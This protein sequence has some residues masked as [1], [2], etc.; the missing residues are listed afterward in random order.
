M[1]AI[2]AFFGVMAMALMLSTGAA[3]AMSGLGA[4]KSS[5]PDWDKAVDALELKDYEAALPL[6]ANV[7]KSEPDN[8]DA[9]NL[10]GFA[11]RMLQNYEMA[12]SHYERALE[13]DPKH[14]G[15]H[16]YI[17]I[18]YLETNQLEK[19]EETLASLKKLCAFC[20]ERRSLDGAVKSYKR[21]NKSN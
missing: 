2:A 14:K 3:D 10:T 11:Y 7:I 8:P 17:G 15:A 16:E 20:A 1:K 5:H 13:I 4:K 12:F 9:Q 21:A 18:S 6:L 19:A